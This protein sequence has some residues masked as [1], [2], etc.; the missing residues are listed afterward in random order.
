VLADNC[1]FGQ[2][3]ADPFV[4]HEHDLTATSSFGEPVH[5]GHPLVSGDPISFG[6]CGEAQ[7]RCTQR[8]GHLVASE[9][10]IKEEVR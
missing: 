8:R 7:A 2:V 1:P 5:V 10:A 9:T 4:L 3:V 6:K